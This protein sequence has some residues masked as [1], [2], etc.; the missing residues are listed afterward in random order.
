MTVRW[1]MWL[2]CQLLDLAL[3]PRVRIP[4]AVMDVFVCLKEIKIWSNKLLCAETAITPLFEN[5]R[6]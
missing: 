1:S 6:T 5:E 3:V 2:R 4:V